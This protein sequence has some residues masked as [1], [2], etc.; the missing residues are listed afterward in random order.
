[1]RS[2]G[3]AALVAQAALGLLLLAARPASAWT[4]D[5][6]ELVLR[7]DHGAQV[8]VA[9]ARIRLLAEAD[10]SS[11]VDLASP[12]L[13]VS[14]VT[15]A[16]R[17]QPFEKTPTGWRVSLRDRLVQDASPAWIW[18]ELDYRAPAAA[19]LVFGDQHVYTAFATCQWLPCVGPDLTRATV[20]ITL[21]LPSGQRF[22]AS[23][24]PRPYPLYTLGFAAGRFTE[25]I[26]PLDSR[27][28][29]LGVIDDAAALHARFKDSPRVLDFLEGKA[30]VP[31]P[32][33]TYT[34]VLVP[35]SAAQEASNFS[36]IGKTMLDPILSEPQEDWVI[37]HE[38]A[39]QW[40]GNLITAADRSE[41]WLNEG[42]A[43]FM[44]A[45]WKQHRWGDA[46]YR[47]E[48]S[49][50]DRRWQRARDVGFDKPLSWGGEYPSLA[51]RRAIQYSKGALFLHALREDM[52]ELAFWNGLR[53]YTQHNAGH[54]V[55][56]ADLQLAMEISAGR[57]LTP[58]FD[59]WVR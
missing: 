53:R 44:T 31:L 9:R 28:R 48:L 2:A 22:V 15:V 20:A 7:P 21:D 25:A 50:L 37:A 24:G 52:G 3:P 17:A 46:A 54:S 38:M 27:L 8:L 35:G 13:Q 57:S 19:G 6:Y 16:G 55:R 10:E 36:V 40:W 29:Y 42:V 33:S 59:R 56:S 58:L 26:D 43:V 23:A 1:M 51:I 14:G 5:H 32:H 39:H 41:L 12:N 45:A 4:A 47:D 18:L 34:Q 11:V 49:L 30:G